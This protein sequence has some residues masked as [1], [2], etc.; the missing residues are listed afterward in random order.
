MT[1]SIAAILASCAFIFAG[2][3]GTTPGLGGL[4]GGSDGGSD[5]GTG[6]QTLA[7][8]PQGNLCDTHTHV[9]VP[10]CHSSAECGSGQVCEEGTCL[11]PACGGPADCASGQSCIGG[12]CKAS[13]QA[14]QV[15]ACDVIPSPAVVNTGSTVQLSLIPRDSNNAPLYYSGAVAWSAVG[16][17]SIDAASGLVTG[18]GAGSV[19]V[20]ATIGTAT[21]MGIVTSYAT[22]ASGSLRV[23]V[24]DQHTKLPVPNAHVLLDTSA[25]LTGP[26]GT[27]TY[28]GVTGVHDVHVFAAGFNYVSFLQTIATDLLVPL[29][30][31]VPTAQRSGFAGHMCSSK[32]DD[33]NCKD[34]A[35]FV[36][37]AVQGESVHLAFF[38]SGIPSSLLDLSIDTLVGPTHPVTITLAGNSKTLSLPYGLVLGVGPNLFGTQDFRM[39]ADGG[40]RA[41]WGI[42]GNV[43]FTQA[44]TA[45]GPVLTGSGG[46]GGLDIG[47]ILPQVLPLLSK[48]EAGATVGV[49]A[50]VNAAPPVFAQIDLPLTTPLRLRVKARSPSLPQL[51]GKYLDG[52]LALAG[53]L[54][55][56]QG[57]VPLGFTAGLAYKD[58]SGHANGQIVD[59]TCDTS[60][61]LLACAT[62]NVPLKFAPENG[63]T[64]GSSYGFA[65]V[66][67]NLGSLTGGLQGTVALSGLLSS[68]SQVHYIAPPADGADV[69]YPAAFLGLPDSGA[70]TVMKTGHV[71]NVT[72]NASKHADANIQI[73]RFELEN[74]ARLGWEVWMA[75]QVAQFTLPYPNQIDPALV[76]PFDP[77]IASNGQTGNPTARILGLV[78]T[79]AHHSLTPT[80]LET[81][82]SLTLD[83]IG[84]N[85]SGFIAASVPIN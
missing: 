8:C 51:D 68:Q 83:Q 15:K 61:G 77:A 32:A 18:N 71:V 48:L 7:E 14:S 44:L 20:T 75:P 19:T 12:A 58:S 82:G 56:P 21:C 35:Q 59:P 64:E 22:A 1:R 60:G 24:I 62:N 55:Y 67:L 30:P 74:A 26:D 37:L 57:F 49:T 13:P 10:F 46:T 11:A 50:P 66:A 29:K 52:V 4:G 45:L 70:V 25:K 28:A 6:C 3:G 43:N 38:G 40:T 53:A 72:L 54:D 33:P 47:T 16:A 84:A 69:T 65:L 2:C 5:G 39:Y 63:G 31:Y 42:G 23:T 41:L 80:D 17:G 76:D 73:Y 81:F 78:L 36:N 9:C 85:L 79:D 34:D 27:A